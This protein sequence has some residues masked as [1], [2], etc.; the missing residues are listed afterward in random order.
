MLCRNLDDQNQLFIDIT[1]GQKSC[2]FLVDIGVLILIM[3]S[4]ISQKRRSESDI[5]A[6]GATGDEL[7][8]FG[9]QKVG[10]TFRNKYKVYHDFV[11]VVLKMSYDGLIGTDLM[12][13]LG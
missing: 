12:K 10:L 3:K 9:L 11:T 4:D 1:V 8:V 6:R 7:T 13:K 5:V 2:I